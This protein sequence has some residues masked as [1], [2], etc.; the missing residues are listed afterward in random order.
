VRWQRAGGQGPFMPAGHPLADLDRQDLAK[1][2]F[3]DLGSAA[4]VA[5]LREHA[6]R[7]HG[8]TP[9]ALVADGLWSFLVGAYNLRGMAQFYMDMASDEAMALTLLDRFAEAYLPAVAALLGEIGPYV[10]VVVSQQPLR[11]G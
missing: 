7:L 3:P 4:R 1:Y 2:P 9:Y 6:E 5:G 8:E 10:E 11:S